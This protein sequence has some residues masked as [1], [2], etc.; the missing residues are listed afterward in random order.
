MATISFSRPLE[1]RDD[2]AASAIIEAAQDSRKAV[3]KVD[4]ARKLE[5]GRVLLR[6]RYSR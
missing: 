6:K 4:I 3:K 5:S 2:K 1:I